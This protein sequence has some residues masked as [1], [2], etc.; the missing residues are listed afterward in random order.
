VKYVYRC[1]NCHVDTEID[2][3]MAEASREERCTCGQTLRRRYT[4]FGWYWGKSCWDFSNEGWGDE[5]VH[6]F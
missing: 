1:D 4:P 2:K 6:N 3:P 5:V